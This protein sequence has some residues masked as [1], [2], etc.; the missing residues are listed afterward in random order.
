MPNSTD[1][2]QYQSCLLRIKR[3][4]ENSKVVQLRSGIMLGSMSGPY[5]LVQVL[6]N[7]E[8][9][10]LKGEVKEQPVFISSDKGDYVLFKDTHY[11]LISHREDFAYSPLNIIILQQVS[12]M[13]TAHS[14]VDISNWTNLE[15]LL[16]DQDTS[17]FHTYLSISA[18]VGCLLILIIGIIVYLIKKKNITLFSCGNKVRV[19]EQDTQ[20]QLVNLH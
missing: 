18:V 9:K 12:S 19:P 6:P 1:I 14:H 5:K 3:V 20:L 16:R 7:R 10:I 4:G 2:L 11:T 13:L 17:E 8:L 15:D